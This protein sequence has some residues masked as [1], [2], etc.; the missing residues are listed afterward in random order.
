MTILPATG[1]IAWFM[2]TNCTPITPLLRLENHWRSDVMV[3]SDI[4]I[5]AVYNS[6]IDCEIKVIADRE[7]VGNI[8]KCNWYCI[9][10][11]L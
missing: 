10:A 9:K 4:Q 6:K 8:D 2:L 3:T 1:A 7:K 5:K 11:K